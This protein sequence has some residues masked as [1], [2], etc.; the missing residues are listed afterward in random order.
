MPVVWERAPL[1]LWRQKPDA[2]TLNVTL[3]ESAGTKPGALDQALPGRPD[4][5]FFGRD[6]TLYALD[7]AFDTHRIVL[8]HAYAGS[9]KTS[10]AA[11]FARWYALTGG[12]EGPVLFSSF[13]RHLPLARVLDKIGEVFGQA[14][15]TGG[16]QWN[17]ITDSAQRR[18]IALQVLQQVPLLWIWDN[19]EPVTGFPAGAA[20]DWSSAEQQE[21][22]AFLSAARDTRA[23]FLLTSRRDE[24]GW[25]GDLPRRVPVPAMPM[26]ERLQLAG[27]IVERRGKKLAELPELTPLLRF[28]RG[29]PLTVVVTVGEA[30]RAGIDTPPQLKE[31]VTALHRGEVAFED[32]ASEGRSKSLGA[33]LSYG[34]GNAF[35]DD[36][37][38]ILALLHLFQGFVDVDALRTMGNPDT[39]WCLT[40]VRGL[41]RERG[42][43]LLD[44]AAE[45]GLLH[46]HGGGYYGIHPALPWYF[47]VLFARDF[48]EDGDEANR[49]RRAFVEAMG[50]LGNF[51]HKSYQ[52]SRTEV[53]PTVMVE[54]DNLL[55]AWRL[56]RAHGWWGAVTSTMQGLRTLYGATGR[57]A[58]WRRLVNDVVPDFIDPVND[59][60]L[61]G[62]ENDWSMVTDYRVE[63]SMQQ[64]NLVEAERLQRLRV[65]WNRKR[66]Q[67]ALA[68]DPGQWDEDQRYYVEI[69]GI[70]LQGLADIQREQDNPACAV[71]FREALDLATASGDTIG[72]GVYAFNLGHACKDVSDLRNL[73]EAERWYRKSLDLRPPNDGLGRGGCVAQLG[74]VAFERFKDASAADR[75]VEELKR[76]LG[77]AARLY[78]Q[79]L[80]MFPSTAVT[81]RGTAHNMLGVISSN[82]G[83]VERA[84]H[85]FR[86]A[87]QV[88]DKTDD[89]FE[90]G[91]I[92]FNVALVLSAANRLTEAGAYAKASL[93]SYQAFSG[94]AT[95]EIHRV[96]QLIADI[97]K[98]IIEKAARA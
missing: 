69:L 22:R 43:A 95:D 42:I 26:Q 45:I 72:Q 90:A 15:E 80:N 17:A 3:D 23:K 57:G 71:T 98:A 85:H 79:A 41:T 27:A 32:E 14:L 29:N 2:P 36:E 84:L 74:L 7:R 91:R 66:A 88:A 49:A 55:A 11:E 60:P 31:F 12:V 92:R 63:L 67:S 73:D 40:A 24:A 56:A 77:E 61:H 19:I 38:E 44:R 8:L 21:L 25:L 75:P 34:F 54:E 53:L 86:Q 37:R 65:D 83:D 48:P 10:T 46:T 97:D 28:T 68:V 62:R 9:G 81:E 39:K 58:A 1:R 78:D 4:V 20:S 76:H 18:N 16:I 50:S 64:R 96:Q 59:G 33:S 70:T 5:G 89:T 82:A 35:S 6:E 87:I 30:L 51:Y 47:R 93:A 52:D 94:A 13:E